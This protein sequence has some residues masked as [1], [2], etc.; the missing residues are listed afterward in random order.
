M[1]LSNSQSAAYKSL[2]MARIL[3]VEDDPRLAATL[4]RVLEA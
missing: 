3:V 4:E 2:D 1:F